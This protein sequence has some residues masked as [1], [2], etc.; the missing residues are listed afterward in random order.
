MAP[1]HFKRYT[2][3]ERK[4]VLQQSKREP[5]KPGESYDGPEN[6]KRVDLAKEGEEPRPVWIA[7]ELDPEEEKKLIETLKEYRD[8]FAWSYHDLKGVDPDR[9]YRPWQDSLVKLDFSYVLE[10]RVSVTCV[11]NINL[12]FIEAYINTSLLI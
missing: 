8:V 6:S 11:D 2:V 9:L 12:P 7:T 10:L 4:I 1:S 5:Q 3:Q